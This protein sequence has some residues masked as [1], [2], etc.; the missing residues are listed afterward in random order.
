MCA[1]GWLV[2][3]LSW[4]TIGW[5]LAYTVTWVFLLDIIKWAS[6]AAADHGA[7][8]QSKHRRLV[9][10]PLGAYDATVSA[11]GADTVRKFA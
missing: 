2:P 11:V 5:V 9:R 4:T 3:T 1:Y 7:G 8:W 6:Y 10:Q